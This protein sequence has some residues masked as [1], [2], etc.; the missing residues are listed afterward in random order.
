MRTIWT[1]LI[2]CD[3]RQTF[4]DVKGVRARCIEAGDGPPLIFL[5]GTGGH[6]EAYARNLIEHAKHFHVYSLDMI[7]HGFTGAPDC[8]YDIEDFANFVRDFLDTIGAKKAFISGE[9]LGAMTTQWF[10][11]KWPERVAKIVLNT[12]ILEPPDDQG[13]R[14]LLE[15]LERTRAAA[16][17]A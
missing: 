15:V 8:N 6:A 5:H 7:G 12:G 2:G 11:I 10:A 9:S 17:A 4:Y 1:D 3:I 16:G 14:E 13:R